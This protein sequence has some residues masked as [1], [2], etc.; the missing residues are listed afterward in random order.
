LLGWVQVAKEELAAGW[1][2]AMVAVGRGPE[3][4]EEAGVV[5]VAGAGVV[6]VAGAAGMQSRTRA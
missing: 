4:R 6:M 5:M 3:A 1:D 2:P